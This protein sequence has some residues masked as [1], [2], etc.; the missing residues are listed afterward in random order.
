MEASVQIKHPPYTQKDTGSLWTYK[1]FI[2]Y[3]Y[4]IKMCIILY[5]WKTKLVK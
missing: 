5:D 1:M 3:D 2:L 4:M